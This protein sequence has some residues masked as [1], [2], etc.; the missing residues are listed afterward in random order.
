MHKSFEWAT[1]TLKPISDGI[2][3]LLDESAHPSAPSPA[4]R[5]LALTFQKLRAF[6]DSL[7]LKGDQQRS[8]WGT[9][10]EIMI[11]EALVAK[12]GTN[13]QPRRAETTAKR[14]FEELDQAALRGLWK[15]VGSWARKAMSRGTPS[16]LGQLAEVYQSVVP[17]PEE[18]KAEE[19]TS[20][21]A[22]KRHKGAGKT[23]ILAPEAKPGAQQQTGGSAASS[24]ATVK[25]GDAAAAAA[26]AAAAVKE[27]DAAASA[28]MADLFGKRPRDDDD[29]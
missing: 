28:L 26:A 19:L 25:E 1:A 22:S 20:K 2:V 11:D 21:P 13:G 15:V 17:P 12:L 5:D 6:K 23:V 18:T 16:C 7:D 10:I 29:E 4:V 27:G 24:S 9:V 8:H 3:F 14:L